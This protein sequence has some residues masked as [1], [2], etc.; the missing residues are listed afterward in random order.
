[1]E[2][3]RFIE[4]LSPDECREVGEIFTRLAAL[5]RDAVWQAHLDA[6]LALFEKPS[7]H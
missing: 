1:M 6:A 2:I 5:P 7:T 4:R 3:L